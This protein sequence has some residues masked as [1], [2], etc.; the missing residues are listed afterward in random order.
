MSET[1]VAIDDGSECT[2]DCVKGGER[3]CAREGAR[4]D[5]GMRRWYERW[6]ENR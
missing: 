2:I 3:G 6:W 1:T 4:D 5:T